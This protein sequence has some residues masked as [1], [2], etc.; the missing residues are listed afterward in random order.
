MR[1]NIYT[2]DTLFSWWGN[3]FLYE[4]FWALVKTTFS[5]C[6]VFSVLKLPDSKIHIQE[7]GRSLKKK[8]NVE[9]KEYILIPIIINKMHA[10]NL[11]NMKYKAG[12]I[13]YFNQSIFN[14]IFYFKYIF[15]KWNLLFVPIDILPFPTFHALA[16]SPF[17]E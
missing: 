17:V 15:K 7:R 10:Y 6:V 11:N 5:H 8:R 14:F 1:S 4:Q 13:F 3:I 12:K 16:F 9:K 2:Y